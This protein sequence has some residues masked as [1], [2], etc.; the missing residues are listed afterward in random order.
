MRKASCWFTDGSKIDDNEFA[1][2]ANLDARTR[3][4]NKFRTV[5]FASIFTVEAMAISTTLEAFFDRNQKEFYIFSES[6]SVLSALKN[7]V[8][9]EKQKPIIY[10]IKNQLYRLS[11]LNKKVK[12][13]WIPAHKDITYNELVDQAAKDS[14]KNGIDTQLLISASDFKAIW[15]TKIKNKVNQ[16]YLTTGKEKGKNYSNKFYSESANPWFYNFK[17]RRKTIV[18]INRLRSGH[19]SLAHSLKRF[20]IVNSDQ[21]PCGEATEEPNH[22][23]WQC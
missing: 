1:G 22:V 16:W 8:N 6:K 21:C 20:E 9:S 3:E 12:L 19:T 4:T 13:V 11:L 23:F 14:A 5:K 18:S 17:F 10:M 7:F 2:F 15:K